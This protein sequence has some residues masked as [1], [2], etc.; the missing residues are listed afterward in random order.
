MDGMALLLGVVH[1]VDVVRH[2]GIVHHR[3]YVR[4]D[5][6]LWGSV[7]LSALPGQRQKQSSHAAS[8]T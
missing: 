4:G 5:G 1:W 3:G 8:V 2:I 6:L 7:S